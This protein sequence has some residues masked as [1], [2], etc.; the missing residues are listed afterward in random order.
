MR[1]FN[2]APILILLIFIAI[3]LLNYVLERMRRRMEQAKPKQPTPDMGMRRPAAP[4]SRGPASAGP[5]EPSPQASSIVPV[6]SSR[7]RWSRQMLF[8]TKRDMRRTI[9]AMT[10][11]G[12]CRANDPPE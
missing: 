4:P 6:T 9:V 12:P 1:S 11:L 5:R 7:R 8:R 2:F 10:I 3:P